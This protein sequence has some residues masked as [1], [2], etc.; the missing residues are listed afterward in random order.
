MGTPK[1]LEFGSPQQVGIATTAILGIS[2][3]HYEAIRALECLVLEAMAL[4]SLE[5]SSLMMSWTAAVMF[6]G[7]QYGH[8]SQTFWYAFYHEGRAVS[9]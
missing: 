9:D 8:N 3:V 4:F 6:L 2:T 7:I 5:L 1:W